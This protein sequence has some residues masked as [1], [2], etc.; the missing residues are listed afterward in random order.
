MNCFNSILY[1]NIDMFTPFM[2]LIIG[3]PSKRGPPSI[4]PN[5]RKI[6]MKYIIFSNCSVMTLK[7]VKGVLL[8]GELLCFSL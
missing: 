5:L 7:D 2:R 3:H 8:S 4:T 6:I 1:I